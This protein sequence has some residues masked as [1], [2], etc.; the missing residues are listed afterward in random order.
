MNPVSQQRERG[1]VLLADEVDS[2]QVITSRLH[3]D[4]GRWLYSMNKYQKGVIFVGAVVIFFMLIIPPFEYVYMPEP[5]SYETTFEMMQRLATP[6]IIY[7]GYAFILDQPRGVA[8]IRVGKLLIQLTGVLLIGALALFLLRRDTGDSRN[9]D[10]PGQTG[11]NTPSDSVKVNLP[12]NRSSSSGEIAEKQH[13]RSSIIWN[14]K[15]FIIAWVISFLINIF[16]SAA[17]GIK[18]RANIVW[19]AMWIYLSIEAWKYWKWKA[20][21]P[22]PLY[23]LT[24]IATASIMVGIGVDL[25]SW[26]RM[27]VSA[28]INICGLIAFYIYLHKSKTALEGNDSPFFNQSALVPT[29]PHA[30]STSAK[31]DAPSQRDRIELVDLPNLVKVDKEDGRFIAY[32][33]GT[34]LD[35]RTNLMWAAKDNGGNINWANAKTYCEDYRGGGYTD[36]RM[37]TRDE[38]A[39]LYDS[40][41]HEDNME[42]TFWIWA[43]EI[44]GSEA[45]SFGFDNGL[46]CWS[47]QSNDGNGRALPVRNTR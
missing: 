38:L 30:P 36:W 35:T 24:V 31:T 11:K 6:P 45:A 26:P 10:S 25:Y 40:G 20:L 46:S 21:L 34:V 32:S 13:K 19:T 17:A 42:I 39:E 14:W 22:Y 5:G 33:N 9:I 16:L 1:F 41:A 27:L 4:I 43:S 18:P 29:A 2:I 23:F 7:Q 28:M 8:S 47:P 15:S 12:E 44:L 3:V 37:P